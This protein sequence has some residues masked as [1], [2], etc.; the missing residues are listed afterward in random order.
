MVTVLAS[1]SRVQT[2]ESLSYVIC[3]LCSVVDVGQGAPVPG[4]SRC[5]GPWFA[6]TFPPTVGFMNFRWSG[7]D[8]FDAC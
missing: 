4:A 2:Q 8:M 7:I 3:E 1:M 5:S 6:S